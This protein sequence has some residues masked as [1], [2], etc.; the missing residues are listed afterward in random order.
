MADKTHNETTL[1][2]GDAAEYLQS[3]GVDLSEEGRWTIPVGNKRVET[4]PGSE[5]TVETTV[6][7]RSRL[8]GDD[9]TSVTVDLR[10]KASGES[11]EGGD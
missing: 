4:D 8:L 3:L 1:S 9:L 10:W 2:R 7:E 11:A 6:D 5:I